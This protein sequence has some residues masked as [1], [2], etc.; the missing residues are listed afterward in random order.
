MATAETA[1][2]R[3]RSS[4]PTRFNSQARIEPQATRRNIDLPAATGSDRRGM[5]RWWMAGTDDASSGD[6]S[7]SDVGDTGCRSIAELT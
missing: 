3:K 5:V 1:P 7:E 6:C 2:E 4:R